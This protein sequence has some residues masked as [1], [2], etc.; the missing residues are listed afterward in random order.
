MMA[1]TTFNEKLLQGGLNQLVSGSVG[2]LV[3]SSIIKRS[4]K[5]LIMLP[6]LHP[7]TKKTNKN[8]LRS[9]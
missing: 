8:D 3:S 7:E 6:R 5:S 2:Q 9:I 4:F 1:E